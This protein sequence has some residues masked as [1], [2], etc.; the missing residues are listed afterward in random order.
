MEN[1]HESAL[2]YSLYPVNYSSCS[3]ELKWGLDGEIINS[4]VARYSSLNQKH[5]ESAGVGAEGD[6]SWLE[7]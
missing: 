5:L 7:V 1:C 4:G 3:V 2:Q 6:L